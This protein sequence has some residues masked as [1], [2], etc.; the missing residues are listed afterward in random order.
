VIGPDRNVMLEITRKT[1][2][3]A[4]Q[5][6]LGAVAWESN[7][8]DLDLVWI[9]MEIR[10]DGVAGDPAF[11]SDWNKFW[12]DDELK[13]PEYAF[14]VAVDFLLFQLEGTIDGASLQFID[15]MQAVDLGC[16]DHYL[17]WRQWK[18][19]IERAILYP[20]LQFRPCGI[21]LTGL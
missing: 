10:R 4:L 14:K 13:S 18:H 7:H 2:Y 20:D 12:G 5:D 9:H 16:P 11:P 21:D 17:R 1:G 19:S 15:E 8:P 3:H 6:L